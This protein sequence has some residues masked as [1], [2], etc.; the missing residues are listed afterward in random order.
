MKERKRISQAEDE[1]ESRSLTT[2]LCISGVVEV[3]L[4]LRLGRH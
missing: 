2:S 4:R 3:G 1:S